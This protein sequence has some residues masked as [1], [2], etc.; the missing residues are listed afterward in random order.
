MWRDGARQ[1]RLARLINS[2]QVDVRV[3]DLDTAKAAG[4]LCGSVGTADFVDGTVVL[5]A[6]GQDATVVTSDPAGIRRLDSGLQIV[7]C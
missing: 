6:R 1:V 7:P 2:G 5:L 4:A 3:L